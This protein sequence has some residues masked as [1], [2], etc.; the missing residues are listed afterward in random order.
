MSNVHLIKQCQLAATRPAKAL[1][2][3]RFADLVLLKL[4]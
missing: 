3:T 2:V 1:V 4:T